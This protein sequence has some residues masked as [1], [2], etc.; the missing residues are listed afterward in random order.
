MVTSRT[1]PDN[2]HRAGTHL[3]SDDYDILRSNSCQL[4]RLLPRTRVQHRHITVVTCGAYGT[5][6][7]TSDASH[8]ASINNL[9]ACGRLI[10]TR[11]LLIFL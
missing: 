7:M 10:L 3:D 2:R 5:G 6:G 8:L 1:R 4:Y 9:A 11:F